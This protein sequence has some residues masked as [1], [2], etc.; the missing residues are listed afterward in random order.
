MVLRMLQLPQALLAPSAYTHATDQIELIETHMSWLFLTGD[1]VYK[2]KKTVQ[3]SFVDFSTLARRKFYCDEEIRLNR[4]FAADIYL[5]VLPVIIAADGELKLGTSQ[6]KALAVEWAVQM[7]QFKQELQADRLLDNNLLQTAELVRFGQ[8]LATQH[9]QLPEVTCEYSAATPMLDNFAS[10]ADSPS[11]EPFANEL[12]ELLAYLH[13]EL[14]KFNDLLQARQRQG[15]VRECHGDLHLSNMVR[16]EDGLCAFDCLE[17]DA[18]L[19][20]IDVL[21]DAA[22][23]VMDCLT[24]ERPDLAYAFIDGYL[25]ISGDYAGLQILPL[26]T[27]YRSMVRAKVAALRLDQAPTD[28]V[29]AAKLSCH[30]QWALA[31]QHKPTGKLFIMCGV[32][33]TGKSYWAARLVQALGAIRIRSDV[34]RKISHGLDPDAHTTSEVGEGLYSAATS[35]E[36]YQAMANVAEELLRRGECVIIDAASLRAEQ[37]QKLYSAAQ[38]ANAQCTVLHLQADR[39][40]L[41]RRISQRRRLNQDPSEA[42]ARVLAWQLTHQDEPGDAEPVITIDTTELKLQQLLSA[43][44]QG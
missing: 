44:N 41:E 6:D 35:D 43:I 38:A 27:A 26:F 25:E 30:I 2:V 10:L 8:D 32:S 15:Y 42:D 13:S 34:L 4:R 14:K 24:R 1:Y 31:Q 18:D 37:R 5:Q 39:K 40:V 7:V 20:N 22:F 17:F 33:G 9:R 16:T 23:L 21:C 19:R 29:A 12:A 28:D 36:T 3:F 11:T